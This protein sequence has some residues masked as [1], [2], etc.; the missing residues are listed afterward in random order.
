MPGALDSLRE[1]LEERADLLEATRLRYRALG[2]MVR[3]FFW[4]E[5]IRANLE[6]LREVVRAE[7]EVEATL[8]AV[9]R[10]AAAERWPPRS[11]PMRL[12]AELAH[13]RRVLERALRKRLALQPPLPPLAESLLRL[14]EQ[15]LAAGPLLGQRLWSQATELLP[16]NLPELRTAAAA[17][18]VLEQIFKRPLPADSLPFTSEEATALCQALPVAEATL[19]S[20]WERLRRYDPTGRV[21][22]LLRHRSR[23]APLQPPR[24]GPELLLYAAFWQGLALARLQALLESRL[25]PLSVGE[26]ELPALLT[27]LVARESSAEARLPTSTQLSEGRAALLE[28]AAELATLSRATE[29][30]ATEAAW[31]RLE[32]AA[33]RARSA[34]GPDVERLRQALR[35]FIHL[36]GQS[37]TPARL[38]SP[39]RARIPTYHMDEAV[40]DLP[41]LVQRARAAARGAGLPPGSLAAQ[42]LPSGR[43]R[44]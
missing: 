16:R 1:R 14:E 32:A 15:V 23:R 38:F 11:A 18:E 40:E 12:L 3:A 29:S 21:H 28:L 17:A 26:E 9:H 37:R 20:L 34:S 10:R 31:A 39:A 44:G 8:E 41:G 6:L 43:G 25:G 4:R 13:W 2:G 35:L 19:A 42:G 5:R 27:W 22:E 7:P 24:S 36:S 30:T 33:W